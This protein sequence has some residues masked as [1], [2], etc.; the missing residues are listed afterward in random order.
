MR[1]DAEVDSRYV[2]RNSEY[3]RATQL[4]RVVGLRGPA[5]SPPQPLPIQPR[6]L[7]GSTDRLPPRRTGFDPRLGYCRIFPSGKPLERCRWSARFVGN[8]PFPSPFIYGAAPYSSHFTRIGSQDLGH[9]SYW[10]R[11][12]EYLGSIP[13]L[14]IL[15]SVYHGFPTS[16]QANAEMGFL[17]KA[18]ADSFPNPSSL[19]NLLRLQ[20][21]R[22]RR[23][24][25]SSHLKAV[26]DKREVG[27]EVYKSGAMVAMSANL[28]A[29]LEALPMTCPT[30]GPPPVALL[31]SQQAH[32]GE[33]FL[34]TSSPQG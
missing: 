19:S 28:P 22:C 13:C 31:Q 8:L 17:T 6:W 29:M 23:D 18:M 25:K 3:W 15:I 2:A 32:R 9:K 12:S 24:V 10:I 1:A 14:V 33:S 5:P 34:K 11:I 26:H 20:R 16:L 30:R 27:K 7:S 21:T 4:R